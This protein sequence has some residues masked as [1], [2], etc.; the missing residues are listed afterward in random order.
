MQKHRKSTFVTLAIVVFCDLIIASLSYADSSAAPNGIPASI[1]DSTANMRMLEKKV[2]SLSYEIATLSRIFWLCSYIF[3]A[4]IAVFGLGFSVFTYIS[5]RNSEKSREIADESRKRSELIT[6]RWREAFTKA[7]RML[8]AS[9]IALNE[10]LPDQAK[11]DINCLRYVLDL[12]DLDK[13]KKFIAITSL[14]EIA[15]SPAVIPYLQ[16]IANTDEE[17]KP[18]AEEAIK[19]IRGRLG[20]S[21]PSHGQ[22]SPPENTTF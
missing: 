17:M 16:R 21:H 1:P 9:L 12:W 19:R 13:D 15:R 3:T 4:I 7:E 2:D 11:L 18:H 20:G 5:H 22:P 14:G 6:K 10:H 8:D